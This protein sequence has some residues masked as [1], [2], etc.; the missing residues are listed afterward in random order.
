MDDGAC[1]QPRWTGTSDATGYITAELPVETAGFDGFLEFSGTRI[2]PTQFFVWPPLGNPGDTTGLRL[3]TSEGL[4]QFAVA[5]GVTLHPERGHLTV[6]AYDCKDALAAGL[7]LVASTADENSTLVYL[8]AGVPSTAEPHT[9]SAG[10]SGMFNLPAGPVTIRL[11][12]WV[13]QVEVAKVEA[14]IRPGGLTSVLLPPSP[15]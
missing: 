15:L 1:T 12:R 9:D 3:L 8:V 4:D 14:Q 7:S 5:V 11:V 10:M 2:P 13:D 6:E